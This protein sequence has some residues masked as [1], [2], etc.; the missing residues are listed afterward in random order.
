M[1]SLATRRQHL[2]T[3]A[4]LADTVQLLKAA[5]FDLIVVETAG[6]G[7]SDTEI[8][9]L[10]D[11]SMYVM[12]ARLR[13]RQPAREDRHA[14]LRGLHR[15]QQ[16]REA[17]R[18]G[19][20]ARRAQAGGAQ[21]QAVQDAARG[22][23]GLSDDREP[24][25]RRRRQ[26]AV[27][28]A[29]REAARAVGAP[30]ALAAAKASR[31]SACRRARPSSRARACATSRRSRPGGRGARHA[32]TQAAEAAGRAHGL[33]R[34][35]DALGDAALPAP[36]ER[37]GEADL[38]PADASIGRLRRAYN[39]AL[40]EVG[41]RGRRAAQGVA[42]AA[43]GRVR[44]GVQLP[45]AR[46]RG[47]R[48]ELQRVALA[49]AP[50]QDRGAALRGLGRAARLPADR[51]PAG[52]LSLHRRHLPVPARGRGPD[53]HVRGRGHARAHQPPLPLPRARPPGDA[54]VDRVRLDDA[55]RRGPGRAAGHLRPHRQL[56][57]LDRVAR[58]HE[59]ALFRLRPVR[60][61]DLGVD[62]D[63]RAGADDPRDVH[64]HRGRPAG[65][66]V[67]ARER[68][69]GRR[70]RRRSR[71]LFEGRERPALPRRAAR[72]PRRLRA[73]PARR[74]RRRGR[75]RGNLRA[76]PRRGARARAR[77]G[78][79]RHPQGGP[80]AEHLHLL[81][82][83]RAPDDGR[84]AAVLHGEPRAELLLGVDLRLPHRGGGG[85]PGLA[86]RVHAGER[87][88]DRRVLP[89]ARHD[90]STTSRRTSRSS[91]RTAWTRST[92]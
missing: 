65:R 42:G 58:R 48:A 82:R 88:H 28:R 34:A 92:P 91:S 60:A 2:A 61:V 35:L 64:E 76:D 80:G 14:R 12:T 73:R 46:P 68:P 25:Q 33:Y 50:A 23:A 74:Q 17:R 78:A 62:D 3:S 31:R 29:V 79:G 52:R 59:A 81:D 54:A 38:A 32:A 84:R 57:R 26:C 90:R 44:R 24:V 27:R 87:L 86:A 40:D 13:R 30:P 63:Q 55:L 9:D 18:R 45:R 75:R 5:G 56:G 83:V 71:E 69:L 77:H 16:V 49:P 7:Q 89:V 43:R 1:R 15:A 19:R 36:L 41:S 47:A 70:R 72:R 4:V 21:P 20:A 53:P 85:E 51:E 67:A 22:A 11:L 66:E 8:V 6:I 10:V 37:Y 39:A